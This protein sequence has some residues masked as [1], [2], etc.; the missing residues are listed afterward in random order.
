MAAN[1]S[2]LGQMYTVQSLQ[3][4]GFQQDHYEIT[5]FSTED[6]GRKVM[7]SRAYRSI[8]HPTISYREIWTVGQKGAAK[9]I[10]NSTNY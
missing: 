10:Y 1:T 9:R 6:M 7:V 3:S 2:F 8:K 5:E 4:M